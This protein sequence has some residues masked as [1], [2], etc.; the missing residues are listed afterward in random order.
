MSCVKLYPH[1]A[2]ALQR[3]QGLN[4]VGFYH[5][6][7]L[8]KTYTGSEKML[9]LGSRVNLV[10]CQKSKLDDWLNH[11][12]QNYP[13]VVAWDLSDKQD[14][15]NFFTVLNTGVQIGVINYDLVYR[16]PELNKLRD[17]TL[18]LD[19]SSLIQNDQ[20]KRTRA[21][22]KLKYK[23]VILLSG[24]PCS[25]KYELLYSQLKLLGYPLSK[26]HFYNQYVISHLESLGWDQSRK[27]RV[28]DGYKNVEH[29]KK[30]MRQL[31]CDFLKTTDVIDLPDQMFMPVRVPTSKEY[32]KFSK[33]KLVT[34][35]GVELVGDNTLTELL[36]LRKLCGIFSTEKKKAF[37]DILDS[38]EDGLIVFYNFDQELND[39]KQTAAD[40]GR[41]ISEVNGHVKDLRAYDTTDNAVVFA[42]YQAGAKGL[43]LQKYNKIIYFT[44]TLSAEDFMQSAKRIHRLG[45]Q[46]PCF[47][48]KLICKNSVEEN[49]YKALEKREDYTNELFKKGF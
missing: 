38:T 12:D 33:S 31:G 36:C 22:L 2:D 5:D 40:H 9:A 37:T 10:V 27:F 46:K 35:D 1:Q 42:Q 15:C 20:A 25:G 48:Y 49:I 6:M 3:V 18:M 7:G 43:N 8:G 23:N 21:I 26:T 28:I 24:T 17:F 45:Q 32:K 19:E 47:Y 11:F 14:Y 16:R 13:D 30:T 39:L 44:P 41:P 34:V 4:N 29:L